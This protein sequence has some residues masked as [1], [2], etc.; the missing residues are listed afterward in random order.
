MS[1]T[2]TVPL[3]TEGDD[4]IIA[5]LTLPN[6]SFNYKPQKNGSRGGGVAV[7]AR[8]NCNS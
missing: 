3:K 7:L 5:D 2:P 6:Y 8:M 4:I 1:L